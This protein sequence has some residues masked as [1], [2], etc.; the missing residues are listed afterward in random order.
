MSTQKISKMYIILKNG[1]AMD[2]E[3][4][5]IEG[6]IFLIQQLESHIDRLTEHSPYTIGKAS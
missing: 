6:V 1:K 4:R 5:P 3:P 2:F